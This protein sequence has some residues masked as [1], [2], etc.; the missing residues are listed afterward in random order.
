[1]WETSGQQKWINVLERM[2]DGLPS[3]L[4]KIPQ[5]LHP[6]EILGLWICSHWPRYIKT[7]LLQR[8]CT[9]TEKAKQSLIWGDTDWQ[10]SNKP[11]T[12]Q[13]KN[14]VQCRTTPP[15]LPFWVWALS[16]DSFTTYNTKQIRLAFYGT[17]HY[18][19]IQKFRKC[20]Q[21]VKSQ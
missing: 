13:K 4:N 11:G 9:V 1:M 21:F 2:D 10:V 12:T 19:Y 3:N 18:I 6:A 17:L 5:F 8:P 14:K 16:W 7:F 20:Q 15:P